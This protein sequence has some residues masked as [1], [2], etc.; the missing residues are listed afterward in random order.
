MLSQLG[1]FPTTTARAPE[2]KAIMAVNETPQSVPE[3]LTVDEA[4]EILRISKPTVR[5]LLVSG[6]LAGARVGR[7]WRIGKRAVLS[8]LAGV[9]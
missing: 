3:T 9:Q 8:M 1:R 2:D 4:A 6:Q 5:N 7:Q